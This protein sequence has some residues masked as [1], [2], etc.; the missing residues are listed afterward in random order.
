MTKRIFLCSK[1][2]KEN[3]FDQRI[4]ITA[5]EM[6]FY[7]FFYNVVSKIT[8]SHLFYFIFM[9]VYV[10]L[11]ELYFVI[12]LPLRYVKPGVCIVYFVKRSILTKMK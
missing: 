8:L 5:I 6:P 9:F 2:Y 12:F 4:I 11:P 1:F 3:V 7:I 10:Y